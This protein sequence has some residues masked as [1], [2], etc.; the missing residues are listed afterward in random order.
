MPVVLPHLPE[1]NDT[2]LMRLALAQGPT[3]RR[4]GGISPS[5]L[6]SEIPHVPFSSHRTVPT[7]TDTICYAMRE[8]FPG[9]W[10]RSVYP[11]P[12]ARKPLLQDTLLGYLK[13]KK[14]KRLTR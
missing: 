9:S 10:E 5:C 13:T 11:P 7:I 6:I 3:F 2:L 4:K 12:E 1:S 14:K 8:S